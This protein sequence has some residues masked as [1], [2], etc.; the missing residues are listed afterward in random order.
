MKRRA[1]NLFGGIL[2]MALVLA[3][4]G[5][6]LAQAVWVEG[7]VTDKQ[8]AG[9]IHH[10][11]LDENKVYMLMKDCR[12]DMRIQDRPGAYIEKAVDAGYI[13]K[14]QRVTIKAENNRCYQV[15]ILQ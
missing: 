8:S 5:Q 3:F 12:V 2:A 9:R 6:T 10:I 1:K 13:R 7:T 15:L 4:S 11:Q 14:G